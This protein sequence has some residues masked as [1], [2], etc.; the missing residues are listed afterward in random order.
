M[1]GWIVISENT[2]EKA[3]AIL[4]PIIHSTDFR[5]IALNGDWSPENYDDYYKYF[6]HPDVELRKYSILIFI[7][8]LA[9]WHIGSVVVFMPLKVRQKSK[10]YDSEKEY[11]FEDYVMSFLA[12]RQAIEKEFSLYYELVISHLFQ[13][14]QNKRFEYLFREVDKQIFVDLREILKQHPTLHDKMLEDYTSDI[15][16]VLVKSDKKTDLE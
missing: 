2:L 3:K 10:Y 11:K 1:R 14:D 4:A 8:A 9:H 15:L 16:N 12:N 5:N 13:H 7:T 6:N